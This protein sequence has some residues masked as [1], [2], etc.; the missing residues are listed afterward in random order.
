MCREGIVIED[1]IELSPLGAGAIRRGRFEGKCRSGFGILRP[2]EVLEERSGRYLSRRGSV[3]SVLSL[4]FEEKEIDSLIRLGVVEPNL[5]PL[6]EGYVV[7][8]ETPLDLIRLWPTSPLVKSTSFAATSFYTTPQSF[9]DAGN[10][11]YSAGKYH[12]A[13]EAYSA[14][15]EPAGK[16]LEA[17]LRCNRAAVLLKLGRPGAAL[18]DCDTALRMVED[19]KLRTKLLFRAATAEYDLGEYSAAESRLT[20]E[21]LANDPAAIELL[22]RTRSRLRERKEGIYDWAT[23]FAT[24]QKVDRLDIA[25]YQGPV[26]IASIKGKGRGLIATR[27]IEVGELLLVARPFASGRGDPERYSFTVGVNTF[28]ESMDPYA[29]VEL[30]ALLLEKSADDPKMLDRL[31]R[32]HPGDVFDTPES[33]ATVTPLDISRLEGIVTFNSFHP[34][35]LSEKSAPHSLATEAA[36]HIHSPSSLYDLPSYLNHSCVGNISYSFLADTIF[37]RAKLAVKKGE[38]LVDSYVDSL[39]GYE[40]RRGKIEKH[41]F[42]CRC[43]LCEGDQFAGEVTLEER[44]MAVEEVSQ[45]TDRIHSE[46]EDSL[47]FLE[48]IIELAKRVLE[49]YDEERSTLRPGLYSVYRLLSQTL[50]SNGRAGE[51]MGIE[52]KALESLGARFEKTGAVGGWEMIA[53]TRIGDV[54]ACLSLLFI[55]KH[56]P[57]K[58]SKSVHSLRILTATDERL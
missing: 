53:P 12:R 51:A 18:K 22:D 19:E 8:V 17:V 10:R 49:T 16:E 47:P 28:T 44:R 34:E 26:E 30:I 4:N 25:D 31:S 43:E 50:A 6:G 14:G 21:P 45:L 15:I 55:A 7:R 46:K 42:V 38:E 37:F 9:K 23:L 27:D 29:L 57:P 13:L 36:N 11:H 40:V 35:S 20:L 39:E 32:L 2:A 58:F 5:R 52:V 1:R 24:S 3:R 54:N 33:Q 41:G 48:E 56:V